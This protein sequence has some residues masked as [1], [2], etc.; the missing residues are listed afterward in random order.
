M[1]KVRKPPF[2]C[3]SVGTVGMNRPLYLLELGL[4]CMVVVV[5]KENCNN[6]PLD[7]HKNVHVADLICTQ[8][9]VMGSAIRF[10]VG[11]I[12]TKCIMIPGLSKVCCTTKTLGSE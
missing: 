5:Y 4:N 1:S 6:S 11:M 2:A 9:Y 7:Y 10:L 8:S 3:D 12:H